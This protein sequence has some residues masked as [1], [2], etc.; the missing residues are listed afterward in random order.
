MRLDDKD[1][2][3]GSVGEIASGV[4][5]RLSEGDEEEVLVKSPEE[6][7]PS[8]PLSKSDTYAYVL[9]IDDLR[10]DLRERLAG[11]K[12]PTL[13]RFAD[14]ELPKTVTGKVQKKILGPRFFPADHRNPEV[15]KCVACSTLAKL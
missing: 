3:E 1:V 10:R 12:L 8:T 11:Y 13:L 6:E 4:D 5:V 9:T 14:R 15:Q 2:P 7:I